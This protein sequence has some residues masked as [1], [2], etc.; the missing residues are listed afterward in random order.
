MTLHLNC[1]NFVRSTQ[2]QKVE[3][4]T[5]VDNIYSDIESMTNDFIPSIL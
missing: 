3:K 4:S 2:K 5:E 1:L